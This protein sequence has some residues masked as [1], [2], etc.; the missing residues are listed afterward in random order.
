MRTL[1]LQCLLPLTLAS[2]REDLAQPAIVYDTS[3]KFFPYDRES[4][5]IAA[6]NGVTA[7]ATG[8][9]TYGDVRRPL[10]Y[11]LQL[12][13]QRSTVHDTRLYTGDGYEFTN[14]DAAVVADALIKM[15][16]QEA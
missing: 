7:I 10:A 14:Q 1:V 3:Y 11:V 5:A 12:R 16:A 6:V 2:P 4:G 8:L 15:K 13:N 9:V